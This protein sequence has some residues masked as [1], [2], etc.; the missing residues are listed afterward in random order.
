MASTSGS[1]DGLDSSSGGSSSSEKCHFAVCWQTQ[2][3]SHDFNEP[4]LALKPLQAQFF[5]WQCGA[6]IS[7]WNWVKQCEGMQVEKSVK[8]GEL[9]S[10]KSEARRK[11]RCSSVSKINPAFLWTPIASPVAFPISSIEQRSH[12]EKWLNHCKLLRNIIQCSING[13]LYPNELPFCTTVQKAI[14]F[15][16]APPF[17]QPWAPHIRD[18][19]HSPTLALGDQNA[20]GIG[21]CS[22]TQRCK[23]GVLT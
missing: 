11:V 4:P 22:P 12:L 1:F 10:L 14:Q 13:A 23:P 19:L 21:R 7:M 20:G 16:S 5:W 8:E 6:M 18:T 2:L 3:P 17:S 9:G 15:G